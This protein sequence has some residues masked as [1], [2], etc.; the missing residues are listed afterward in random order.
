MEKL[1]KTNFFGGHFCFGH[2]CLHTFHL[3]EKSD[4]FENSQ[5]IEKN[6]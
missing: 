1:F 5:A 3:L 6:I 4:M 2:T